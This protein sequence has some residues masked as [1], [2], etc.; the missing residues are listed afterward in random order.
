MTGTRGEEVIALKGEFEAEEEAVEMEWEGEGMCTFTPLLRV[1]EKPCREEE[2]FLLLLRQS[3]QRTRER[4]ERRR[5]STAPRAA[6][7][8]TQLVPPLVGEDVGCSPP[9]PSSPLWVTA[10]R[11][12]TLPLPSL[13]TALRPR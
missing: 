6:P 11:L 4:R 8:T 3:R 5:T 9:S 7:S 1:V 12:L 2:L 13:P 10:T